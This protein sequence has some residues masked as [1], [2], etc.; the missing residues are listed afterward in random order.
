MSLPVRNNPYSFNEWLEKRKVN[1]FTADTF[2]QQCINHYVK[3]EYPGLFDKLTRFADKVSFRWSSLAEE[4]SQRENQPYI[5][6]YDGYNNRIDRVV[7][8]YEM[9]LLEKEIFGEGTFRDEVGPWERLIRFILLS[10]NGE[11]GIV[12]PMTCTEGLIHAIEDLTDPETRS[13][14]LTGILQHCKDGIDGEFGVGA[15]FLSEIQGGSDVPANLLEAEFDGEKWNLYGTKFFCSAVHADHF[16]VTAKPTDSEKVALFIVPAWLPGNK[17]KEIRNGHTI[18]RLKVKMGTIEVPTAELT[19]NGAVAYPIGDLDRGVANVVAIVLSY[20]RV[21]V[22][23]SFSGMIVRAVREAK[24]YSEFREAFGKKI[25]EFP[26]LVNQLRE[27]EASA[28]RMLAG[29]FKMY[30]FFV[31]NGGKF[32]VKKNKNESI[33]KKKQVFLLRQLILFSKIYNTKICTQV[34]HDAMSVFGGHGV[35]EDFC[36][37][38]RLYRDSNVNELWEGPRNVL[39]DQLHRDFQKCSGWYSGKEFIQSCL[40]GADK[41]TIEYFANT[42]MRLLSHGDLQKLDEETIKVAGEWEQFSDDF[43]KA[44]Q[45]QCRSEILNSKKK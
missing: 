11:H 44:F 32:T 5:R 14:E 4:S 17:E 13:P 38:P 22:G 8:P 26:L 34:I 29:S 10:E 1:Y 28:Q 25:G 36:V 31:K 9:L 18:D 37:L 2:L 21:T 3:D 20:S 35:M 12:C 40:E 27:Y 16:V 30:D 41:D 24:M 39:L 33:E 23:A 7:R 15:Q 45:D 19:F 6:H 42:M 43:M